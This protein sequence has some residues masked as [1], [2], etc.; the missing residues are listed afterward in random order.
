MVLCRM[1]ETSPNAS[2]ESASVTSVRGGATVTVT[3]GTGADSASAAAGA[4]PVTPATRAIA[5]AMPRDPSMTK[6]VYMN[7]LRGSMKATGV[8]E[9][10]LKELI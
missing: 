1:V 4:H 7:T 10:T 5:P 6:D 3:A 2:H 8:L 9:L